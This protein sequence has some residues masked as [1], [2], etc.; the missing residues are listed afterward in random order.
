MVLRRGL[1]LVTALTVVAAVSGCAGTGTG[2]GSL[3]A[4]RDEPTPATASDSAATSDS[5]DADDLVVRVE[6]TG[7]FTTPVEL[8]SRLPLVSVHADGRTVEPGPQPRIFPA[9]AL[10]NLLVREVDPSR[11]PEL[12]RLATDAGVDGGPAPDL[13]RPPIAD[14]TTT[15]FTVVTDTGRHQ[16][17]AYA[18]VEASVGP[19]R[20]GSSTLPEAGPAGPLDGTLSAAQEEARTD[21]LVLLAALQDLP[22]TLGAD[23]VGDVARYEPRAVAAIASPYD[24]QGTPQAARPAIPW[25]GPPLPGEPLGGAGETGCVT[26]SGEQA[27]AVLEAAAS[28]TTL[29]PWVS[30]GEEWSV[31][32]RPLMP[33]E[34]GC[35]DLLG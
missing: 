33:D 23:A 29:T 25:P 4:D 31:A 26:A 15:R 13:G 12:V 27:R 34:S 16:L 14:A 22:A 24:P 20:P 11:L 18:L 6:R 30:G 32:L 35:A 10:P 7:G 8:R 17:D 19:A 3:A 1:L 28:A 21:L 9:P 2:T 5:A